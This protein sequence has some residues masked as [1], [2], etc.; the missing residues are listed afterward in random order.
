MRVVDHFRRLWTLY[1][2]AVIFIV[3]FALALFDGIVGT[4]AKWRIA[5]GGLP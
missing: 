2:V 4:L 1:V 3:L 5:T